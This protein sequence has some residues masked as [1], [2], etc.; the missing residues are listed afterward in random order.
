[1]YL[2]SLPLLQRVPIPFLSISC[3]RW[4]AIA[5]HVCLCMKWAIKV[6]VDRSIDLPKQI[7]SRKYYNNTFHSKHTHT[8]T[9]THARTHTH[10]HTGMPAGT[11]PQLLIYVFKPVK[12][13]LVLLLPMSQWHLLTSLDVW[14]SY[15]KLYI[16]SY[17]QLRIARHT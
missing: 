17:R 2:C 12:T 9:R 13:K 7:A 15:Q 6:T 3:L 16:V 4:K 11:D 1:M 10:T 5:F 14:Y 8:H